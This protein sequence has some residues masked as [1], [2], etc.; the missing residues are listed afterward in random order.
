ML[1]V[2]RIGYVPAPS[3]FSPE[4]LPQ[5]RASRPGYLVGAP[6]GEL[7][8]RYVAF[9]GLV[10]GSAAIESNAWIAYGFA[11]L[12]VVTLLYCTWR[13]YKD[14]DIRLMLC[15]WFAVATVAAVG[16]G[17]A[18]IAEPARMLALNDRYS[19][20]SVIF[21]C[22]L[23]M[24]VQQKFKVFRTPAVCL[25]VAFSIIYSTWTYRQ[26]QEPLEDLLQAK[27]ITFNRHIYQVFG[28]P[29]RE[30]AAIVKAAIE[31]GRYNPP[32]RPLP[33]CESS[34]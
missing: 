34:E 11:S 12:L 18:A 3:P 31:A 1:L 17:R 25:L 7:L 33:E 14:A 19:F 16:V 29:A 27:Y 20:F 5:V 22:S 24:L 6:L 8:P 30:S 10:L 2:W 23:A 21:M 13:F 28:Y 4:E 26:F 32:C 9:V 15:C